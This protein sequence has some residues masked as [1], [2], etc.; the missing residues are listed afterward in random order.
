M[1]ANAAPRT[2]PNSKPSFWRKS[3]ITAILTNYEKLVDRSQRACAS[4]R[5]RR[6]SLKSDDYV[7]LMTMHSA[8]G[9][10]FDIVF[11][12]CLEQTLFPSSQSL[13]EH[14]DVEEERRLF[15]VALTRA[16]RQ[17]SFDQRGQPL[18][19][20]ALPGAIPI[21]EFLAGN[22]R[23]LARSPR[24][25]EEPKTGADRGIDPAAPASDTVPNPP[26]FVYAPSRESL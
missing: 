4:R 18:H 25:G 9:L 5:S 16:A 20:R 13:F 6:S 8:K 17:V 3:K 7:S 15:Y 22:R 19:V 2:W 21:S 23:G 11:I 26:T 12:A 10:E 1:K 14:A 24:H